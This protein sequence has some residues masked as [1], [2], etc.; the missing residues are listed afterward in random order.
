MGNDLFIFY[1][2]SHFK[3]LHYFDQKSILIILDVKALETGTSSSTKSGFVA[4]E[5]YQE[6]IKKIIL[7]NLVSPISTSTNS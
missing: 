1:N 4:I 6:W 5:F 2:E 7:I 3:S